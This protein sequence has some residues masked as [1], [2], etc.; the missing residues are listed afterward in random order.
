MCML[1]LDAAAACELHVLSVCVDLVCVH[2]KFSCA[3]VVF[4]L[5]CDVGV[6][7]IYIYIYIYI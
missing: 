5:S 7:Y 2:R 1:D 6:R 4:G 3:W